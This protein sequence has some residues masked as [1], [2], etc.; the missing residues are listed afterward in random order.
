MLCSFCVCLYEA[1]IVFFWDLQ[2]FLDFFYEKKRPKRVSFF[3]IC[4]K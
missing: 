3:F 1:K 2:V 4:C